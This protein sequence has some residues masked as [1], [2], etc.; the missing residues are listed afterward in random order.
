MTAR[1][2]NFDS[3]G[4]N[5]KTS[6]VNHFATT[7]ELKR[8]QRFELESLIEFTKGMMTTIVIAWQEVLDKSKGV[9]RA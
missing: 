2:N 9:C 6:L 4:N 7:D 5:R 1:E 8:K 3:M